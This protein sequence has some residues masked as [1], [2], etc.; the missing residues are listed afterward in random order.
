MPSLKELYTQLKGQFDLD[1]SRIRFDRHVVCYTFPFFSDNFSDSKFGKLSNQDGWVSNSENKRDE[2]LAGNV[3]E[4]LNFRYSVFVPEKRNPEAYP[5][6]LLHGLNE[7]SWEKYLPWAY[8]LAVSTHTP[9][10]LFPL[11]NHINRSPQNWHLPRQMTELAVRRKKTYGVIGNS[12][13]ANA[14]LSHRMD[15]SPS[16]FVSSGIQSLMDI[17]KLS[18]AIRN[19]EHPLFQKNTGVKF[20]SYSI[21][22]LVTEILFMVNPLGLFSGSKAF[23]FCGGATFDQMDGR[24][25]SILDNR[26]FETLRRFINKAR[27]GEI[28]SQAD[29][30]L[31]NSF[32]QAFLSLLSLDGFNHQP[33]KVL[34]EFG[35]KIRAVGLKIDKVVPGDAIRKTLSPENE[36]NQVMVAD[37]NFVYTHETPFPVSDSVDQNE[38][39][40]AFR[41]VFHQASLF[42][43]GGDANMNRTDLKHC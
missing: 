19:G 34:R 43:S 40:R 29:S 15:E 28:S 12:S 32:W 38:V 22:A 5:I 33:Q 39:E 25:K 42:L 30:S 14:A 31:V 13:F 20:F 3:S 6:I 18:G 21:G 23:F 26:A 7:R 41:F 24:S 16:L 35:D 36:K 11:A 8:E 10:I 4:N 17:V 37:F 9:V 2:V 1:K 27:E